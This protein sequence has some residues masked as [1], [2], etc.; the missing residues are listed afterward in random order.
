MQ[1][2]VNITEKGDPKTI[3]SGDCSDSNQDIQHWI[4]I[5]QQHADALGK[6]IMISFKP[7]EVFFEVSPKGEPDGK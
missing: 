6:T 2:S 3:D 7:K 5:A 1:Y 4:R